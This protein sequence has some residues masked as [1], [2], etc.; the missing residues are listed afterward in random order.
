M[1]ARPLPQACTAAREA[2]HRRLDGEPLDPAELELLGTHLGTC[3]ACRDLET[4]LRLIQRGLR[5]LPGASFPESAL[6]ATF[7]R[8]SR[9]RPRSW[10]PLLAAAATIVLVLFGGRLWLERREAAEL[11]QAARETR[12]VLGLTA[13]V[14]RRTERTTLRDVLG[15]EVSPALR[16]VPVA[17]PVHDDASRQRRAKS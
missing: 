7:A 11:A 6:A 5:Q 1:N 4:D 15:G 3:G 17:W 10:L 14:L 12:L 16:R 9:A 2:V 8:T 13:D